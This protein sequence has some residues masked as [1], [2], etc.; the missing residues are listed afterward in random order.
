MILKLRIFLVALL[1]LSASCQEQEPPPARVDAA[2]APFVR[3]FVSE[4]TKRGMDVRRP[5]NEI[6]IVFGPTI[7]L[8]WDGQCNQENQ[9]ITINPAS[10]Q[11]NDAAQNRL[12]IFHELGHC[13]LGR[14]HLNGVLPNGEWQSIMRGGEPV[15]NRSFITNFSGFRKEYYLDE[16]FS[17]NEF[18]PRWVKED[19]QLSPWDK[20]HFRESFDIPPKGWITAAGALPLYENGQTRIITDDEVS[21]ISQE[22]IALASDE[23][24]RVSLTQEIVAGSNFS[25]LLWGDRLQEAANYLLIN[26]SREIV[27]GSRTNNLPTI[28]MSSDLINAVG[29]NIIAIERM[30]DFYFGFINNRFVYRWE[31]T[32]NTGQYVGIAVHPSME[33]RLHEMNVFLLNR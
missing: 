23:H 26:N 31:A 25:G 28:R 12:T 32:D 10:W 29:K 22:E 2:F 5:L 16:L 6:S 24:Y 1:L 15:S 18:L 14:A 3:E 9:L 11:Q 20:L 7:N 4:A 21:D 33:V 27:I 17:V 30:N 13:L 19:Y 8:L